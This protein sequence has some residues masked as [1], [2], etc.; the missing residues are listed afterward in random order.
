[1]VKYTYTLV[2]FFFMRKIV[3]QE[4]RLT[5]KSQVKEYWV[6]KMFDEKQQKPIKSNKLCADL[7]K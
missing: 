7:K 4:E 3:L 2:V 6:T 1:M 5:V